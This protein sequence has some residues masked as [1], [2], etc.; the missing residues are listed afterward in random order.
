MRKQSLKYGQYDGNACMLYDYMIK[1]G[2]NEEI[3]AQRLG[4]DGITGATV[5]LWIQEPISIPYKFMFG[6]CRVLNAPC[7]ALFLRTRIGGEIVN[8]K[9]PN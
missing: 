9:T 7:E 1:S 2:L 5:R 4:V 3:I 6:L 8:G